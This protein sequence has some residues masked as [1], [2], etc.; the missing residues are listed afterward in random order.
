MVL[1]KLELT[2]LKVR[3][4]SCPKGKKVELEKNSKNLN[5]KTTFL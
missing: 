4:T 1:S 5:L 2:K 3:D